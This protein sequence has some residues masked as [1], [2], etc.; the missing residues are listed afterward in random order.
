[1]EE[2]MGEVKFTSEEE[3]S[4]DYTRQL[5]IGQA[6]DSYED[7]KRRFDALMVRTAD[8]FVQ[9]GYMLIE[10]R[11][12]N[13]LEG[14]GYSGMG[15]FALKEYGLRPDQSSRFVS[16]T[17]RFGDGNGHLAEQ[18]RGHGYSKLS[19]MLSLPDAMAQEIPPEMTRTEIKSLKKEVQEEGKITDLEVL[20]EGPQED[21]PLTALLKAWLH[22]HAE[23]FTTLFHGWSDESMTSKKLILDA[24]CP[25]GIGDLTARPQGHG[26][27]SLIFKGE[28][29]TPVLIRIRENSKQDIPW[30]DLAKALSPLVQG[31]ET[32][33]EQWQQ[34][35]GENFPGFAPVQSEGEKT[36]N[37]VG[38]LMDSN[39]EKNETS[40]SVKENGEFEGEK[41]ESEA[42]GV[43]VIRKVSPDE[44]ETF[45]PEPVEDPGKPLRGTQEARESLKVVKDKIAVLKLQL[46]ALGHIRADEEQYVIQDAMEKYESAAQEL[47]DA[48]NDLSMLRLK[49][50][51]EE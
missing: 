49:E 9:I 42:K 15:E 48:L 19:E 13:I 34:D 36:S 47:Q 30:I 20:M 33:N 50:E 35:F 2:N 31:K 51:R 41:E 43:A 28:D 5:T 22:E 17:E 10:A 23:A 11:D 21:E 8:N 4:Q 3:K 1:M 26:K 27:L 12:T 25:S 38:D 18:F 29:I 45:M 24:M 16:I 6:D 39:S 44:A 46:A 37:E 40:E 7:F 32:M 14:S